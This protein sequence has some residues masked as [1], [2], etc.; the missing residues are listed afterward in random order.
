MISFQLTVDGLSQS[1]Q[2]VLLLVE[3]APRPEIE[4]APTLHLLT[5]VLIVTEKQLKL[6]IAILWNV[7]VN[8]CWKIRLT[9]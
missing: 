9:I 1:G 2:S 4:P 8:I 7:Q 6:K 5:G 3:E